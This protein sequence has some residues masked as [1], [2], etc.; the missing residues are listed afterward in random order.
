[1]VRRGQQFDESAG[2]FVTAVA[3][4]V[5]I[6]PVRLGLVAQS[7]LFE[8]AGSVFFTGFVIAALAFTVEATAWPARVLGLST[9]GLAAI[10]PVSFGWIVLHPLAN[11]VVEDRACAHLRLTGTAVSRRLEVSWKA[12]QARTNRVTNDSGEQR[13]G[14]STEPTW[15]DG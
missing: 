5:F 2:E 13:A 1:M 3:F 14:E 15:S 6:T 12:G 9:C 10:V 7:L 8:L 11:G 4:A